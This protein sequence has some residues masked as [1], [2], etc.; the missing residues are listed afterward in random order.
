VLNRP[1]QK[2]VGINGC[3]LKPSIAG[4]RLRLFGFLRIKFEADYGCFLKALYLSK[5][6]EKNPISATGL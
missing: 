3:G 6:V 2:V 1:L 5:Y 4:A